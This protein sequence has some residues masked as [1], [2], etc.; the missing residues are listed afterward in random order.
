M[1]AKQHFLLLSLV[2]L[3]FAGCKTSYT[4]SALSADKRAED[5]VKRLTLEEKV[6]LMMDASAPVERLGIKEYNWWNEALHGVGRSGLAT[7]YPQPIGMAA[8]FDKEALFH[9]FESVSDEARA[10]NTH[11]ASQGSYERYQGLTMWTPTINLLRDPRWGRG[12]ETY[13]EDPYLTARM[14]VA[15]VKGLQGPDDQPYDKL[16]ACA[17]HFAVHSGPEWNRHSFNAENID[18]RDLYETYLPAFKA[19]V[20]EGNVQQVMCAYNRF[21][22][23]PCCGSNRL[24]MQI[25]RG[26]WGYEGVVVADCGAVADFYKDYGHRTHGSAAEASAAAVQSGTDLDCGTSY[27]ALLESVKKGL[28]AEADIDVSVR[29]LMKA[30]FALGEMDD[31]GKVS[32][33]QIPYSVVASARHDSLALDMARRSMTLLMNKHSFLP[34][35]RGGQT[36]AVM[37]PNANDS[38]MQWGNYNGT[39]RRTVTILQGIMAALGPDD[40]LIYEQGT[41]WVERT[42]IRSVFNQCQSPEGPGFS[43]RYWNN[44]QQEGAPAATAQITTPFRYSVA[45][46]TVF[47]PGVNLSGFSAVYTSLLTPEKSGEVVFDFNATGIVK[48]KVDGEVVASFTNRHGTRKVSHTM[49][50]EAGKGYALEITYEPLRNEAQ[51]HFDLGFKDDVNIRKSVEKVKDADVVIFV[52][53]ISPSLEGEEMGVDLPGFRGG[54]RTDIELPAVQ[55]ELITALH[56][57]GKKIVMVNC[58]GSPV[59]LVP[60]TE[61]CEAILQ[62][63]YPGQEGGTAVAEVL[64]G[65]YNPAGRLPVTFYRDL[66]QLPDFEDYSMQ[67]RTYRYMKQE[68]LYPFGYGLS[69]TTFQYGKPMLDKERVA[70]GQSVKLTVPVTNSGTRDGDEVVQLYLRKVGD[71]AGPVKTLRSFRRLFI[72]AGK[73]AE[74]NFVLGEK[75]L[76]WWNESIQSV[77]SCPGEY[78]IM[79]GSSSREKDLQAVTLTISQ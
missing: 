55:R 76:E 77:G 31:P 14:G 17:K 10:K 56:R 64:F 61:M 13:G 29:R 68:P 53:G 4:N 46:A 20:T 67:G 21:E 5:L 47:A 62:A 22:G 72:P 75:E 78:E 12:I 45:G 32:W 66:S 44:T 71:A 15:V 3:V 11:Y 1:I 24:L 52:G 40:R 74:V 2:L 26:E 51:L 60:E 48:L 42:V 33:T 54:D 30:R 25:L 38:V 50:V 28:I 19:L 16:H 27:K 35:K 65:D 69:Y 49:A 34:L 6:Q 37:G 73:T 59:A 36:I 9:V 39:P 70:A 58:S 63:W 23:D 18:P 41:S 8:S 79:V 57:A 7:V 43:G